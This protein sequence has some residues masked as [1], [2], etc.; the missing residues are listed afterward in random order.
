MRAISFL[1]PSLALAILAF[2][3]CDGGEQSVGKTIPV[4][5]RVTYKGKP[6]IQGSVTFEPEDSGREAN[7]QISPDGTFVLR[8]FRE[9]DG[10]MPGVHRVKV[11]NGAVG[12]SPK[13]ALPTKRKN[14]QDS[15]VSVEVVDG[16]TEYDIDLK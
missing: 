3:G 8:T 12:T 11:S 15:M 16:K 7:G 6:L 5:G 4:K 1:L 9:G 2:S 10:A 14:A 13:D